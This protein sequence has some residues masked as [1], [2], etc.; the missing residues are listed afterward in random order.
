M[1]FMGIM[2]QHT[3]D[4]KKIIVIL[5]SSF[6]R[7]SGSLIKAMNKKLKGQSILPKT[8]TLPANN[9]K[10]D[11]KAHDPFNGMI[12]LADSVRHPIKNALKKSISI[13]FVFA[14][15]LYT[16]IC[17]IIVYS[18][19]TKI[20]AITAENSYLNKN[21]LPDPCLSGGSRIFPLKLKRK[22]TTAIATQLIIEAILSNKNIRSLVAIVM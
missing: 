20:E 17:V 2:A 1:E 14:K 11:V 18:I 16:K 7:C 5:R 15:L 9:T 13:V 4:V 19:K 8:I 22:K 3:I 10:G 12:S 21:R 6:R